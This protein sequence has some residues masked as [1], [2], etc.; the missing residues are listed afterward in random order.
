[1]VRD[2]DELEAAV[3]RCLAMG[4]RVLRLAGAT[5]DSELVEH[6]FEEMT[7]ELDRSIEDFA[8]RVDESAEGP[9]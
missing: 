7:G 8:K 2:A 1:L 5:L 6:R 4:A 9:A 3:H